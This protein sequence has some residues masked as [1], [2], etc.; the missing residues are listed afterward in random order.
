M[1]T[2]NINEDDGLLCVKNSSIRTPGFIAA[3]VLPLLNTVKP[4]RSYLPKQFPYWYP[5][6]Q[7]GLMEQGLAKSS[8][9]LKGEIFREYWKT[10]NQQ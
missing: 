6:R 2:A 1:K 4:A 3:E 5:V 8:I 7:A 9:I 10:L